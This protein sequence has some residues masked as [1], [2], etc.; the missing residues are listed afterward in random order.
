MCGSEA[1]RDRSRRE[2]DNGTVFEMGAPDAGRLGRRSHIA[3][4]FGELL[5]E[6]GGDS[7]VPDVIA[8]QR[9]SRSDRPGRQAAFRE[10]T[11]F[12]DR[13]VIG[14]DSAPSGHPQIIACPDE[15]AKERRERFD[16]VPRYDE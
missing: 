1:G 14:I 12:R 7:A 10:R 13:W 4:A 11:G 9:S 5:D 15:R 6:R 2:Y 8:R 16:R 3:G